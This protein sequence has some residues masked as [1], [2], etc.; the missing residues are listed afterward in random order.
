MAIT[1]AEKEIRLYQVYQMF[2]NG[3]PR[4]KIVE[5]GR[6]SWKAYDRTIDGY[7]AEVANMIKSVN[8]ENIEYNQKLINSR[9]E[10]LLVRCYRDNDKKTAFNLI[11]LQSEVLGVKMNK[12]D[13]TSVGQPIN[14]KE[15]FTFKDD[16]TK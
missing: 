8:L 5:F 1:K 6:S 10:D 7:I 13:I 4:H 12:I 14:L 16:T 15:L 2:M 9:I 11:K 3:F